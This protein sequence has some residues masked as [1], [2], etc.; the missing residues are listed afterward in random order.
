M[1]SD[2]TGGIEKRFS[3][4][5][6]WMR[7]SQQVLGGRLRTSSWPSSA[8]ARAATGTVGLAVSAS[9]RLCSRRYRRRHSAWLASGGADTETSTGHRHRGRRPSD[10]VGPGRA[11]RPPHPP[12]PVRGGEPRGH[13]SSARLWAARTP[14]T[15]RRKTG[16]RIA[17]TDSPS[18]SSVNSSGYS[19][20][21][22]RVP[23]TKVTSLRCRN[24]WTSI[25]PDHF[26]V[27]GSEV[28][29]TAHR[30]GV[31]P[32]LL[33]AVRRLT[34]AKPATIRTRSGS[35]PF[36]SRAAPPESGPTMWCSRS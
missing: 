8:W 18:S 4:C 35:T 26:P 9:R 1:P 10:R 21:V 2:P 24:G 15:G 23:I 3:P 36:A 30:N 14:S 34:P 16:L 17:G 33:A 29:K 7:S 12:D 19:M 27:T 5:G 28:A 6:R 20:E 11:A 22:D 32:H 31:P 25:P 13:G